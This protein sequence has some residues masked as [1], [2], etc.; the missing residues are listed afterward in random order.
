DVFCVTRPYGTC[1]IRMNNIR[2]RFEPR[3][4]DGLFQSIEE[5]QGIDVSMACRLPDGTD[6]YK[7]LGI[8]CQ[9]SGG[10]KTGDRGLPIQCD[11]LDIVGLLSDR[12]FIAPDTLPTTLEGWIAALVAQL[13]VNCEGRYTVDPAYASK[14]V[15][16]RENAD[17]EGQKCGDLLRYV[18]MATGT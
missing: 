2:S 14:S 11:M 17:V 1:S 5:R 13:G 16:V 18:C 6:E 12:V 7:Q 10:W 4:K 3:R 9:H 8:F 15:T